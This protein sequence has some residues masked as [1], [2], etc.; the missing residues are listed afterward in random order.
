MDINVALTYICIKVSIASHMALYSAAFV[1]L[2]VKAVT[3][4]SPWV[5]REKLSDFGL[6]ERYR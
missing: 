1:A 5:I 4:A 3:F 2:L 6:S